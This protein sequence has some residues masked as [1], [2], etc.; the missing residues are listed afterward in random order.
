MFDTGNTLGFLVMLG[1]IVVFA[2][3]ARRLIRRRKHYGP[4]MAGTIQDLLNDDRRAAVE[5]IL[6]ERTGA[7]DPETADDKPDTGVR[8]WRSDSAASRES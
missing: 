2:M 1:Y 8:R 5:I 3:I 4:A 7:R 6:E